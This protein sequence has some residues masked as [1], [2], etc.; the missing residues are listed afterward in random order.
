MALVVTVLSNSLTVLL[1]PFILE[2]AVGASV[3]NRTPWCCGCAGSS[4]CRF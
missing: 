3:F 4:C 2:R 1:T